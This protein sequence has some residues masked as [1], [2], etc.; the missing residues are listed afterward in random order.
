MTALSLAAILLAGMLLRERRTSAALRRRLSRSL[1]L[2][3]RVRRERGEA[4][5][6]LNATREQVAEEWDKNV[7]LALELDAY[8]AEEQR[9]SSPFAEQ[10]RRLN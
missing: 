4:S 10:I 8:R 2:C 6:M 1:T 3:R 7:E 5:R 9:R